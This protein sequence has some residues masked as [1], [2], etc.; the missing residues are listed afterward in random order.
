MRGGYDTAWWAAEH[1]D[2]P[3]MAFFNASSILAE[4]GRSMLLV[5][6]GGTWWTPSLSAEVLPGVIRAIL[7]KDASPW[8]GGP[9]QGR[10][11]T[12]TDTTCAEAITTCNALRNIVPAHLGPAL[13]VDVL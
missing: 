13:P 5:R 12:R 2:A 1:E 7:L 11:L 8:L 4:G 3:D 10:L 9:L 6:L